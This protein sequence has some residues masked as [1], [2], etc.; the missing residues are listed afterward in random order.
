MDTEF[1]TKLEELKCDVLDYVTA[2]E[3]LALELVSKFDDR[4]QRELSVL[5]ERRRRD[6][7]AALGGRQLLAWSLRRFSQDTVRD[8]NGCR[9]AMTA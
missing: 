3:K 6:G 4:L 9:Q 7:L 5:R 8:K 2:E 1:N